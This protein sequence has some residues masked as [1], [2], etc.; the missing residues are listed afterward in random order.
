MLRRFALFCGVLTAL[1]AGRAQSG[2]I[3]DDRDDQFHLALAA[4]SKYASVGQLHSQ[5]DNEGFVASAVL[6][7]SKYALTTAHTVDHATGV[8][9]NLGGTAYDAARWIVHPGWTGDLAHGYD[10]ALI[11]LSTPVLNVTPATRYVGGSEIGM[12]ATVVGYGKT[13]T[14]VTGANVYDGSK[15]GGTNIIDA[16]YGE[17]NFGVSIKNTRILVADFDN[18][19]RASDSSLGSA[20]PTNLEYEIGPGDSGSGLFVD[21]PLGTRLVGINTFGAASDGNNDGDYGDTF[22]STRISM[23]NSWINSVRLGL[24]PGGRGLASSVT[25]NDWMMP[26][27]LSD[28]VMPVPEPTSAALL[29]AGAAL[30]SFALA[31]RVRRQRETIKT[32]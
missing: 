15:R 8:R 18:P 9:L 13:G 23:F 14:G 21:T 31:V 2:T 16:V 30:A 6:I 12:T 10:L 20:T 25:T 24:L 22:G 32:R 7:G 26:T 28:S 11:E 27:S 5:G 17:T 1:F 3:R 19:H 29:T 4:Q